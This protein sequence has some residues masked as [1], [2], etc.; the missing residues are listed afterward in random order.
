MESVLDPVRDKIDVGA[1]NYYFASTL[2]GFG[3]VSIPLN[4]YPWMHVL[5]EV[6]PTHMWVLMNE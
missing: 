2:L 6:Y 3:G 1:R 5:K 4:A